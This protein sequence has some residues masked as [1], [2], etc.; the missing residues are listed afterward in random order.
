[1]LKIADYTD[2]PELK[3]MS[4]LFKENSPYKDF[5][6]DEDK[7]E[8]LILSLIGAGPK[9]CVVLLSIIEDKPVGMVAGLSREWIFS[10]EKHATEIVWWV[11]PEYRGEA[12]KELQEAFVFWANKGGCKYLHMTLLENKDKTKMKKLYEKQGFKLFEQAWVKE[13]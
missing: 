13:I 4:L 11:D 8:Q 1:V 9:D 12:G 7:V 5:P 6:V 10:K 3:R 2:V